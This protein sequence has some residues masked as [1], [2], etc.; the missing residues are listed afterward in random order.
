M[1]KKEGSIRWGVVVSAVLGALAILGSV[2][3][4]VIAQSSAV[5]SHSTIYGHPGVVGAVDSLYDDVGVLKVDVKG[6]SV[7]QKLMHEDLKELKQAQKSG[8]DRLERVIKN[9]GK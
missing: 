6:L 5:A 9:G 7:H 3:Y 4:F 2:V 1:A 8:F